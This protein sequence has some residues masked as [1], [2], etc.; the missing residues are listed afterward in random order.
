M[1]TFPSFSS[2]L[3]TSNFKI[4]LVTA[5]IAVVLIARCLWLVVSRLY[6]S[7]LSK[8]PGPKLAALTTWYEAWYDLFSKKHG[9]RGGQFAF[10][11]KWM[12]EQYGPIVRVGPNE[13]HIDDADYYNEVYSNAS[14]SKPID[15]LEKYKHRF[16]M[17]EATISTVESEKHRIRRAAI[18]PFFS[19][20]RIGTLGGILLEITE[21]ISHRLATEYSG[22]GRVVD[23]CDMWGTLAA[24]AVSELAF[25]RSTN[26]SAAPDFKSPYSSA[27]MSWVYGAHYTTHF[28][29][30][31][32]M[33]HWMPDRLLAMLVPSFK[34]I[35]DYRV[36]SETVHSCQR[37]T[38]TDI[39]CGENR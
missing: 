38:T 13:L 9:G 20:A 19:K 31:I 11:I 17:P 3:H 32:Q 27:L 1:N 21:R 4:Q 25:A 8:F 18:S 12:H 33:M 2:L 28:P 35:L 26:F 23:V 39:P 36:V 14:P 30:F 5:V 34:P 7:P 16:G 37:E 15:K 6:F 24:D 10:R 29:F 22:T